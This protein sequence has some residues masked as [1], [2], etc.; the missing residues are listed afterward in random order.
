M[1][2][3][4]PVCVKGAG[5]LLSGCLW[6]HHYYFFTFPNLLVM[7]RMEHLPRQ[8]LIIPCLS[9]HRIPTLLD[10]NP[11]NAEEITVLQVNHER[12]C[13]KSFGG[14][15]VVGCVTIILF[16]MEFVHVEWNNPSQVD[17]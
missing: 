1:L 11:S 12:N 6:R 4:L 2:L 13:T 15:L 7:G 5:W 10:R 8:V 9:D 16:P 14:Q 3:S 17:L